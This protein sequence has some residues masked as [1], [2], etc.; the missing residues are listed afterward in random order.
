MIWM[1]FKDTSARALAR[2]S[3]AANEFRA[4]REAPARVVAV[5]PIY[6]RRPRKGRICRR[7]FFVDALLQ[8]ALYDPATLFVYRHPTSTSRNADIHFIGILAM[9]APP[10]APG[11]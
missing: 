9:T 8:D 11:A 10:V 2:L 5:R 3:R 6:R 4:P 7:P 1:V